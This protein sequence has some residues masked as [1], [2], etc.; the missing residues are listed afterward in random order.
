MSDR[1]GLL[2]AACIGSCEL[3]CLEQL[4]DLDLSHNRLCDTGAV[5]IRDATQLQELSLAGAVRTGKGGGPQ[6]AARIASAIVRM[7]QAIKYNKKLIH[8]DISDCGQSHLDASNRAHS[9]AG[10][11]LGRRTP[12]AC[13]CAQL[14]LLTLPPPQASPPRTWTSW[15]RPSTTT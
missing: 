5:L 8:L 15:Q 10:V 4:T 1:S 14:A 11:P 9:P 6:E 13:S 3:R 7:A 2:L 12:R